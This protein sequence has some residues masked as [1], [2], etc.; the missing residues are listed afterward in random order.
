MLGSGL[1]LDLSLQIFCIL[2]VIKSKQLLQKAIS[3]MYS[4]RIY[5]YSTAAITCGL[6]KIRDNVTCHVVT[7]DEKKG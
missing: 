1:A 7:L 5:I 2:S 4:G 6:Y 3:Y